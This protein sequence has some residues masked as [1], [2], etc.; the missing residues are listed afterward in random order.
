M[1]Q[2]Y[3]VPAV[4]R[5]FK[6][7]EYLALHGEA[8]LAAILKDLK[9]PRSSTFHLLNTL[10]S[11]GYARYG[12]NGAWRLTNKM[13][14]VTNLMLSHMHMRTIALPVMR[15]FSWATSLGSNLGLIVGDEAIYGAKVDSEQHLLTKAWLGK[16]LS[17]MG[18]SLGKV[19]MAWRPEEEIR[20]L[21]KQNPLYQK[22]P[23]TFDD[24]DAYLES[25]ST[26]RAE[27]LAWDREEV[28][29]G[30]T[31]FAMPVRDSRGTVL[32]SVSCS[33]ATSVFIEERIPWF[34]EKLAQSIAEIE[35]RLGEK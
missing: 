16:P 8:S 7:V 2:K 6:I 33:A 13:Y 19:L 20:Y 18:S 11:I 14:G 21:L 1:S 22:T 23:N 35:K 25:L 15:Q 5:S 10:Q 30:V 29:P 24:V 26:V 32:A 3:Q 17:L 12:R 34:R 27:G 4:V 9:L 31:C 28:T